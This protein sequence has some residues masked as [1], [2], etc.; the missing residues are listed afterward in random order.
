MRL[1][2]YKE[3][4]DFL[5]KCYQKTEKYPSSYKHSLG[6]EQKEKAME[7]LYSIYDWQLKEEHGSSDEVCKWIELNR[8]LLRLSFDL[9]LISY[10][11]YVET[12]KQL[13]KISA[14]LKSNEFIAKE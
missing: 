12:N 6:K 9:E 4:Y 8:V 1:L 2:I 14:I 10:A 11:Y 5:L 13:K 3:V 7:L